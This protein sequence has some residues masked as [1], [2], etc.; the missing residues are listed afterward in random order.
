MLVQFR[1][2]SKLLVMTRGWGGCTIFQG[3]DICHIPAPD[4]EEVE[5]TGAGDIFATAFLLQY[6]E[7]DG[8]ACEAGRF[9]NH[10]ASQSV[11]QI[12]LDTKLARIK[13]S[14]EER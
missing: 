1:K 10:V 13:A 4:V 8:D 11:T 3:E 7:T 5:P 2:C 9:A 12:G 6:L 14:L